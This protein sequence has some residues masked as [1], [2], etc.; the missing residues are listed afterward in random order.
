MSNHAK[1]DV[2]LLDVSVLGGLVCCGVIAGVLMGGCQSAEPTAKPARWPA[3]PETVPAMVQAADAGGPARGPVTDPVPHPGTAPATSPAP[4]AVAQQSAPAEDADSLD[5]RWRWLAGQRSSYRIVSNV[6]ATNFIDKMEARS[7][8]RTTLGVTL[9]VLSVDEEGAARIKMTY[10]ELAIDSLVQGVTRDFSSTYTDE[11]RASALE[12]VAL[13]ALIGEGGLLTVKATG[14]VVATD[15]FV[16]GFSRAHQ[17]LTDLNAKGML[18]IVFRDFD[19]DNMRYQLNN[20]FQCLPAARKRSG[21]TWQ[22]QTVRQSNAGPLQTTRT[23]HVTGVEGGGASRRVALAA[24]AT[25]V[26]TSNTGVLSSFFA[27]TL[28]EGTGAGTITVDE[29]KGVIRAAE[30]SATMKFD[31]TAA[32][33][34]DQYKFEEYRQELREQITLELLT[35]AE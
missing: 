25:V 15:E 22:S 26:L 20:V 3:V 29:N 13:R 27:T 9:E 21:D 8:V 6:E 2:S 1:Q 14:E 19:A 16:A 23:W 18:P 28:T 7:K 31:N 11:P 33:G 10:D 4:T 24:D 35:S 32:P 17:K 12:N 5:L 30:Y 34:R